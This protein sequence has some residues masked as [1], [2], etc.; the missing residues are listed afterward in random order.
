MVYGQMLSCMPMAGRSPVPEAVGADV[1]L[2]DGVGF[3]MPNAYH[4]TPSR[5]GRSYRIRGAAKPSYDTIVVQRREQGGPMLLDEAL[6]TVLHQLEPL[7]H[8]DLLDVQLLFVGPHLAMSYAC[9]FDH[10]EVPRRQ[11]GVL[12]ATEHGI[13][14]IFMTSPKET[15]NEA[16]DD[17]MS[18]FHSLHATPAGTAPNPGQL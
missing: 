7:E 12:V 10:L 9:D 5:H 16:S 8:F 15:F 6:E 17:Y 1:L 4:E 13:V 14:A 18:L 11:W 2:A 3:V